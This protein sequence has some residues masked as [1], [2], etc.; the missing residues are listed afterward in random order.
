MI[1]LVNPLAVVYDYAH[2]RDLKS[3]LIPHPIQARGFWPVKYSITIRAAKPIIAALP[4]N[5]SE[6]RLKP[7]FVTTSLGWTVGCFAMMENIATCK[8]D[9]YLF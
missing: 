3:Y 8:A 7:N 1:K 2:D 4:L 5:S 6:N 9:L